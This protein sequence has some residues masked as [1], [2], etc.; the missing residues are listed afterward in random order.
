MNNSTVTIELDKIRTLK[1]K[2]KHLGMLEK[3]FKLPLNKINF[4]DFSID[5]YDKVLQI[6]LSDDDPTITVKQ[7]GDLLEEYDIAYSDVMELIIE[8][9]LIA[10]IGPEKAKKQIAL[11]KAL[12]EK[13]QSD[14][15]EQVEAITI[16][17]QPSLEE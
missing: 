6:A 16:G 17:S 5:E 9:Y 12:V 13:K 10:M 8:A 11:N 2:R 7:V 15:E 4:N 14:L 3:Q 1:F